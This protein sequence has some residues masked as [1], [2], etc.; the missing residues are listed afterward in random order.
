M[1][2]NNVKIKI[3]IICTLYGGQ[4]Y[5][6]NLTSDELAKNIVKIQKTKPNIDPN[7][8]EGEKAYAEWTAKKDLLKQQID[9]Q[10][11]SG[12]CIYRGRIMNVE[13][14][15]DCQAGNIKPQTSEY[16]LCSL[17]ALENK[18]SVAQF[19][20][21]RC[22]PPSSSEK[23]SLRLNPETAV[24]IRKVYDKD[25]IKFTGII[26]YCEIYYSNYVNGNDV[27]QFNC[28]ITNANAEIVK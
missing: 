19:E 2:L 4:V 10:T 20:L 26:D 28:R 23:F 9:R 3:I 25:K 12:T 18:G 1:K 8:R 7:S 27:A 16:L 11:I 21:S 22:G 5:A 17:K 6:D 13:D 24:K 14:S 15:I